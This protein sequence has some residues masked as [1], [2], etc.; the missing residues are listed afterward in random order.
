V[1]VWPGLFAVGGFAAL[2][3]AAVRATT[4]DPPGAAIGLFAGA[5]AG[6]VDL[7]SC[8]VRGRAL[9]VPLMFVHAGVAVAGF[10]ALLVAVLARGEWP[11]RS[12]RCI[13]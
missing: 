7:A 11:A 8:H 5:A 4:T 6:G 13:R 2:L 12:I 1:A 9:P 3:G 10:L